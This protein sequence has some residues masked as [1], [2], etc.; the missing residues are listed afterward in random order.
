M[1]MKKII[2]IVLMSIVIFLSIIFIRVFYNV[3]L[4]DTKKIL[5]DEIN[6]FKEIVDKT[7]NKT[8]EII[9]F[10]TTSSTLGLALVKKG[11]WDKKIVLFS[12]GASLIKGN[13]PV[14]FG[15]GETS[16]DSN[17]TSSY[18]GLIHDQSIKKIK[19]YDNEAHMI[20]DSKGRKLWYKI[21]NTHYET[22]IKIEGFDINGVKTYDSLNMNHP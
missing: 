22:P 18:Y 6:N 4:L 3:Y 21:F 8:S 15:Y 7:S 9:F 14:S 12:S 5:S 10:E 2:L 20:T 1:K 17:V 13:N 16:K 11:L 19:I